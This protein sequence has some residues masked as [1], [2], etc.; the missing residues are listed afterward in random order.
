MKDFKEYH[1][2]FLASFE[3]IFRK[4]YE[5]FQQNLFKF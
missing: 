1:D 4:I 5:N 2:T 3:N